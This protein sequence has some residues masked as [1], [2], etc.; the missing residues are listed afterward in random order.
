MRYFTYRSIAR[1]LGEKQSW[2]APFLSAAV[3]SLAIGTEPTSAIAATV[4]DAT[5]TQ[6]ANQSPLPTSA[7]INAEGELM[8]IPLVPYRPEGI[9]IE[10]AVP[11]AG[12]FVYSIA[13]GD[14]A[15]EIRLNASYDG[16]VNE[17]V[18]LSIIWPDDEIDI[19]QAL[20]RLLSDGGW[21]DDRGLTLIDS[22]AAD[23][24][25]SAF[26]PWEQMRWRFETGAGTP[27]FAIGEVILGELDGRAF[28]VVN[29][30]PVE[31]AEGYGSLMDIVADTLRGRT[32]FD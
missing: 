22:T 1:S 8:D 4:P 30:M 15:T 5:P 23:L 17:A 10:M 9:P 26:H 7:E 32:M 20:D 2:L 25:S 12:R 16:V 21:A 18:Y 19:V 3:L 28:W 29:Y 31:F 14:E 24:A 13:P 27:S 6:L 11:L